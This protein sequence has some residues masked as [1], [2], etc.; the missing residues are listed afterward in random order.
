MRL[1]REAAERPSGGLR[2]ET[3]LTA[4]GQA[5]LAVGSQI[6][7]LAHTIGA[8]YCVSSA[9]ASGLA[10]AVC[11]FSD[12]AGAEHGLAYSHRVFDRLIPGRTLLR[13]RSTVMTLTAGEPNAALLS[14]ARRAVS[15]FV[16]L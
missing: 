4:L 1:A 3:V 8:R 16:A 5:G 10:L 7:V 13:N 6:Q 12:E 9:T 15:A 14:E 11:E 2:A